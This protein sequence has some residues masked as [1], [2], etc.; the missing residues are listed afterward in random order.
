MQ[1]LYRVKKP[2]RATTA[3]SGRD[4]EFHTGETF[5]SDPRQDEKLVTIEADGFL[6]LVDH[7]TFHECCKFEGSM[8]A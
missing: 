2:F 5:L 7:T 3:I 6:Y 1:N 8:P 4:H